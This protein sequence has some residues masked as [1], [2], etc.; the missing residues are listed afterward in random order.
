VDSHGNWDIRLK[1]P[2]EAGLTLTYAK[3]HQRILYTRRAAL[4]H[5]FSPS[6]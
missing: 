2:G 1:V 6:L 3:H 4:H 5:S